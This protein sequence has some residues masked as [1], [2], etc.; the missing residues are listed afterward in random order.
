MSFV[1][2]FTGHFE[3]GTDILDFSPLSF[4]HGCLET[5]PPTCTATDV[6]ALRW[7]LHANHDYYVTIKVTN[8]AGLKT[9]ATSHPYK[10]NVRIPSPGIVYDVSPLSTGSS[11]FAVS[12]K[13]YNTLC[14]R[15]TFVKCWFA[16]TLFLSYAGLTGNICIHLRWCSCRLTVTRQVSLVDHC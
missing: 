11:S 9:L 12:N 15:Y 10:H 7:V 4:Q 1:F 5:V 2:H 3:Y 6:S 14:L 16:Y 8:L 13:Y